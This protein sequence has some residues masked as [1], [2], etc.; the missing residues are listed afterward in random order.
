MLVQPGV[1]E[2]AEGTE[3]QDAPLANGEF[4]D[5][6]G[7]PNYPLVASSDSGPMAITESPLLNHPAV[8]GAKAPVRRRRRR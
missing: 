6:V 3:L 1:F 7:V 2:A 5:V 4:T 8:V